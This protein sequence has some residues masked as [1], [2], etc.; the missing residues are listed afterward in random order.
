M[1]TTINIGLYGDNGHQIQHT[2]TGHA[3]CNVVATAGIEAAALPGQFRTATHCATLEELLADAR[4]Q[5]VSLCSPRR[6][7][8]AMD[9]VRCLQAGKHVYA[10]KP[11]ALVETELDE[12]IAAAQRHGR[13]FREQAGTAFDAP[14]RGMRKIVA[15]GTLGE[16]VQVYTQKSYP[17]HDRRPQDEA[18]DAGLLMQAGIYN[19]RFVEHIAGVRITS[20]DARETKLGNPEPT[21]DCRRAVA[22]TMTL[23]NGGLASAVVNYLCPAPPSWFR[24]GYETL[25][26]WGTKGMLESIDHGR[27]GTLAVNGQPP[28]SLDLLGAD[29]VPIPDHLT[30]FLEE[31]RTG[32]D[33]IP[34]SLEDELSSTRWVIRAKRLVEAR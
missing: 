14:Y 8:Q 12:I 32:H 7:D 20:I 6:A 29:D 3:N 24:W 19:C 30:M 23:A 1:Q 33:V 34:M 4:V 26:I 11:A 9:A 18:I 21:G 2:L 22:M 28:R 13:R 25:R 5:V 16:I 27:V 15:T 17:W 31:V 10:E